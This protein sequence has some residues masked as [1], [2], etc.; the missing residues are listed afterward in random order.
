MPETLQVLAKTPALP[1]SVRSHRAAWK[2][3]LFMLPMF[4][5]LIIVFVLP[6]AWFLFQAL[7]EPAGGTGALL[8]SVLLSPD[9][10]YVLW[11]TNR[12]ALL[13]TLVTLLLAYPIAYVLSHASR[14]VFTLVF[15]CVILPYFT[16]V[17]VRTYA[18]MILLGSNGVINDLL[19][20]LGWIDQPLP[21]MYN[22]GGV[23]IGLSYVLLPYLV[24]TLMAAM[25]GIDPNLMR[26]ARSL[27][28][29]GWT[30]FWRVYFPLS[31]HGVVSGS[32]IVFIL[33]VGSFVTPALM[34]GPSDVML[35]M[36]IEREA[37]M[38]FNW[39]LAGVLSL[40][41]LATTM[42]LY[43]VYCKFTRIDSMLGAH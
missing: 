4:A 1:Q 6:I 29:S 34:G 13:I 28:A 19:R 26:A 31:L 38:N 24:L 40:V 9:V 5:L 7:R 8:S 3:D 43:A 41:L 21:L 42:A 25:K 16:S 17:I 15:I 18:W 27:G 39:P 33:T 20:R 36:L 14:M 11:I 23:V 12:D 37:E 35:A 32:L 2:P 22:K 10:L 30:T